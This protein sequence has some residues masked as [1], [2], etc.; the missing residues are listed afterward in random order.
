[1]HAFNKFDTELEL[2]KKDKKEELNMQQVF[3]MG[4]YLSVPKEQMKLIMEDLKV[5]EDDTLLKIDWED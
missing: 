1:M 3:K 2:D 5:G 4:N